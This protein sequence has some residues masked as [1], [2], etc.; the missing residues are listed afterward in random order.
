MSVRT[1]LS[2]TA[3]LECGRA[4]ESHSEHSL[5]GTY[6]TCGFER[7]GSSIRFGSLDAAYHWLA[8]ALGI[9]YDQTHIGQFGTYRCQEVIDKCDRILA[10]RQS[11]QTA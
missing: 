3:M 11:A 2:A 4:P 6:D 1:T 7:I 8:A 9:P 5:M 10:M